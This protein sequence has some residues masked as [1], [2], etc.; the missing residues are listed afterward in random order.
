MYYDINTINET[1]NYYCKIHPNNIYLDELID[2]YTN[3]NNNDLSGIFADE[4]SWGVEYLL[5]N[6]TARKRGL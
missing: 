5:V 3:L 6:Y 1:I 4:I 2:I